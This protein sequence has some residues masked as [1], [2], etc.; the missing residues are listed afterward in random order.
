MKLLSSFDCQRLHNLCESVRHGVGHLYANASAGYT[1]RALH[2][3]SDAQASLRT[4]HGIL[5]PLQTT[6]DLSPENG[7]LPVCVVCR[8]VVKR[9]VRKDKTL[10]ACPVCGITPFIS[11]F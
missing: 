11:W 5:D 8:S 1:L 4:I 2:D 7:K 9:Q 6:T 3:L 10:Y